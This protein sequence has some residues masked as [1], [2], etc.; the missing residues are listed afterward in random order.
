MSF[1]EKQTFYT[2]NFSLGYIN[3][4]NRSSI[5]NRFVLIS[6]VCYIKL[7]NPDITYYEI[8]NKFNKKLNLPDDFIQGLAI[9]CEDFSYDCLDFPTFGLKGKEIIEEIKNIL[10]SY[11][12]F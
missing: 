5:E 8:L 1:K 9:V 12:P 4:G 11:L 6:L 10:N 3:S 2:E 7:K